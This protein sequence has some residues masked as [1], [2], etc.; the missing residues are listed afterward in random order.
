[1]GLSNASTATVVV[2]AAAL[3]VPANARVQLR[4]VVDVKGETVTLA[5]FLPSSASSG[6]RAE[7]ARIALGRA[8][9]PGSTRVFAVP[10]IARR[11]QGKLPAVDIA[12]PPT[13]TVRRPGWPLDRHLIHRAIAQFL[14]SQ[15]YSDLPAAS[16]LQWSG[17]VVASRENAELQVVGV[18]FDPVQER[19]AFS[20]RCIRRS[21]CPQF[22]V[23][24]AEK[25]LG[26]RIRNSSR[27]AAS[28]S[29]L[30]AKSI[31]RAGERATL[32]L[33]EAGMRITMP[34]VCLQNGSLSE[35]IR[36]REA[37]GRRVFHAQVAG[38]GLLR[39]EF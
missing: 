18:A 2:L 14:L 20:T 8:P 32:M 12:I 33:E 7:A 11:L 13:M 21:D 10:E 17:A 1:M 37:N 39:A 27:D 29:H 19:M 28:S 25:S 36:V 34:V 35:R 30:R 16:D 23:S 22:V 4:G 24:A 38:R 3:A 9:Q 26:T 6:V 31:A 15:G 5:D